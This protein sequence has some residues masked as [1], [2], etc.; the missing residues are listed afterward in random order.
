MKLRRALRFSSFTLLIAFVVVGVGLWPIPKAE[1][2]VGTD[3]RSGRIIDDAIF[4][5]KNSMSV[6]QIQAFLNA[7]VPNCDRNHASSN[8]SYQ[9]PY[10]CLKE[11]QENTTTGESNYGRFNAD[12]TP[13][14]V[15]GSKSAAQIIWEEAQNYGINP[16]TLLVM[17]Q[18]EQSLVTDDWPWLIQYQKAMGQSCPDTAPC[19][20]AYAGFYRQ[21][22]GAAWQLRQY[23][24]NPQYYNYR[25]GVTR[26]VLY[27]P[28]SSC[29]GSSV[30]IENAATA[31]LY[32]Y[33]PYQPNAAAL[34]NLYGSGDGC[35][36]YG[37]RNFWRLFNDWF[38]PTT[39]DAY[40]WD[41]VQNSSNGKIYLISNR[42]AYWIPGPAILTAWGLDT[43]PTRSI[44]NT[45]LSS[46][47]NGP[48][49]SYVALDVDGTRYLMNA[50]KKYRL[51]SDAY[52][53]A[54][55]V[56]GVPHVWAPGPLTQVEN[57]G[58]AGKFAKT[59]TGPTYL[60]G[61]Y[62]KYP[63]MSPSSFT[64]FGQSS[65]NT[66]VVSQDL[67]DR[68]PNG[69][70]IDR[71]IS[72]SGKNLI[73][74]SGQL[75]QFPNP[76]IESAWGV[77]AYI[78]IHPIGSNLFQRKAATNF[79]IASGTSPWYFLEGGNRHYLPSLVHAE[80]WGWSASNPLTVISSD[81]LATMNDSGVVSNVVANSDRSVYYFV[82]KSKYPIPSESIL[83]TWKKPGTPES[84]SSE[85]LS[86]LPTG[87]SITSP[88]VALGNSI[89]A[90]DAGTLRYIPTVQVLDAF[91]L[92][93]NNPIV[94]LNG[95]SS[96]L[97]TS[98][99]QIGYVVKSSL[100]SKG[101]YVEKGKTTEIANDS[102]V[103][104][105]LAAAP[106]V[107]PELLS[108]LTPSPNL[109]HFA[110]TF[111][112]KKYL[113]NDLTLLDVTS[114]FENYG[115]AAEDFVATPVSYVPKSQRSS[116][117]IGVRG[118][119]EIWALSSGK[120]YYIPT[121]EILFDL[122]YGSNSTITTLSQDIASTLPEQAVKAGRVIK[123]PNTGLVFVSRGMGYG[124]LDIDTL[125]Q[126]VGSTPVLTLP[127]SV[128]E[129]FTLAGWARQVVYATDGK[130]YAVELGQ[131]RWITSPVVLNSRFNG[132]VWLQLPQSTI[133]G[134][135][136]GTPITN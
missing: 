72:V 117:L 15:P 29:G 70:S 38:G 113:V 40:A 59:E 42:T 88:V 49:L 26:T 36:A 100:D 9:P 115:L 110:V 20:P 126:Y 134:F 46:L 104:W 16:Q 33:T 135:I 35:S 55:G 61:G 54:W 112:G 109:L 3:W 80:A 48:D 30:Y 41:L 81:L 125:S 62:F 23:V 78:P 13:Y 127:Y 71:F 32:N 123:A 120:R 101:Y 92:S 67:L 34:N 17:L 124:F 102:A 103:T 4:F 116:H 97:F 8:P 11:Y 24:T 44:D 99:S 128:F 98:G 19:D 68:L 74:D 64:H 22:S 58:D 119:P 25:A 69:S 87:L 10:T 90:V 83:N 12:G 43:H 136:T 53:L 114:D 111:G 96:V 63:A 121:T 51:V 132:S 6:A 77:R 50:G 129:K 95:N 27:N 89:F 65:S 14:Q 118:R 1:S 122:G 131:K 57:G 2:V 133:D 91:N 85:S 56:A 52:V 108:T 31:A 130:V 73:A 37:N 5:N 84:Y 60:M 75:L 76:A 18:K 7:K 21:V 106:Q 107:S 47:T 28:S 39:N 45:Y 93:P 105:K 66:T 79:V 86:L 82:A 94:S